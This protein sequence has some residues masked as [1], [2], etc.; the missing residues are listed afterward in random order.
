MAVLN[1]RC[2]GDGPRRSENRVKQ[3]TSAAP[4]GP[5]S[6][7]AA[8]DAMVLADQARPRGLTRVAEVSQATSSRPRAPI[9]LQSTMVYGPAVTTMTAAMMTAAMYS[10]AM[11]ESLPTLPPRSQPPLTRFALIAVATPRRPRKPSSGQSSL[12]REEFN[13]ND[14]LRRAVDDRITW[15]R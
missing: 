8:S 10:H 11:R 12:A 5:Q 6:T 3:L 9:W 1:S 4:T 13:S 2:A 14:R 7:T 15:S